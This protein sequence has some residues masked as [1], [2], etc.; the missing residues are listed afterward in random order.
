MVSIGFSWDV[1]AGS[2]YY[3]KTLMVLVGCQLAK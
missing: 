3:V 1:L 2:D